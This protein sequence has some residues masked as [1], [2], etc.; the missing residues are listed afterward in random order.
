MIFRRA[1]K[2]IIVLPCSESD[3]EEVSDLHS[4]SFSRGWSTSELMA[5][6]EKENTW[7]LV[8]REVGKPSIC[9]FN[10]VRQSDIEAE[11]ISV[12]VSPAYRGNE[13][14]LL[15]MREAINKLVG[16]R[17]PCLFLEVAEGNEPAVKL[18]K[19]LGFEVVGQRPGYFPHSASSNPEDVSRPASTALVMR[20]DLG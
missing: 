20:L 19:R 3:L 4:G 17:V 9:G 18:Y 11:I 7:I 13:I 14:G 15:L 5:M 12:A 6:F 16:D 10:I 2:D 1:P 8:A